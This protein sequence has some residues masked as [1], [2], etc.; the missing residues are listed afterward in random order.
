[1][2][3]L[4]GDD[5][6]GWKAPPVVSEVI[7]QRLQMWTTQAFDIESLRKIE[8]VGP[9][10]QLQ[11]DALAMRFGVSLWGEEAPKVVDYKWPKDWWEAFK[12]RWAPRWYL[13]RWPV[14]YH[15]EQVDLWVCYPEIRVPKEK[16]AR[17]PVITSSDDYPETDD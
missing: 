10:I 16:F 7:L 15:R 6:G 8:I 3:P 11:M 13:K 5:Y 14:L 17:I 4:V 2:S 1:M 12:E 9:M